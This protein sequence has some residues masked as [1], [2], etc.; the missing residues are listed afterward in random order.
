MQRK[1]AEK[2]LKETE[3]GYDLIST[4]FSQTRKHFWRGLEFIGNYTKAGDRVLDYG[5]GNGRLLELIG[6]IENIQYLGLDVSKELIDRAKGKYQ[7]SN[8]QF[9]KLNIDQESLALEKNFFNTGYSIAVFHHF[10]SRA[11]RKK[12]AHLIA[13]ALKDDG[14]IIVTVWYLWQKKYF[15]NILKNWMDKILGK[16]QLDWND[17]LIPF[18][19]NQGNKFPRFHHAFTKR[20]LKKL[21]EDVG[22]QTEL[23]AVSDGRNI[24]YVGKKERS[25]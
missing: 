20:E 3:S 10:P 6:S 13:G 17:C 11:Y 15:G 25:V 7:G 5:C 18:T 16:S 1:V 8:I 22:F 23:C 9:S 19:D 12:V 4:K 21:F 2:I 24:L 14:Y